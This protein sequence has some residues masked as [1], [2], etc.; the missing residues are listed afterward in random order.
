MT[1]RLGAEQ[2]VAAALG[3]G[4]IRGVAG[5]GTGDERPDDLVAP[6]L[7][8]LERMKQE[9]VPISRLAAWASS[10]DDMERTELMKACVRLFRAYEKDCRKRRLLD[11]EDLLVLTVRMLEEHPPLLSKYTARYLHV[12][13]DEYQDL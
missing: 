3:G 2:R 4:P 8:M 5:A 9:L 7:Q 1:I 13:V 12:L 6:A 10:N 11:F